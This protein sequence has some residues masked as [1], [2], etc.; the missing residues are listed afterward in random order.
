MCLCLNIFLSTSFYWSI[1]MHMS[2]SLSL[3]FTPYRLLPPPIAPS[4]VL[5]HFHIIYAIFLKILST[6]YSISVKRTS[7]ACYA[8]HGRLFVSFLKPYTWYFLSISFH[9]FFFIFIFCST[10]SATS[11]RYRTRTRCVRV[12][13]NFVQYFIYFVHM[14]HRLWIKV[15]QNRFVLCIKLYITWV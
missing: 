5:F 10:K 7:L 6:W 11:F 14:I 8:N 4:L 12:L 3:L 2:L 15:K 13:V 9:V 1:C